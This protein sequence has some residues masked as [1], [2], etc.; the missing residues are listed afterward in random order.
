[1]NEFFTILAIAGM[2]HFTGS[3]PSQLNNMAYDR[4]E[5]QKLSEAADKKYIPQELHIWGARIGILVSAAY[6]QK[7][8]L[9]VSF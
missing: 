2:Y 7:V 9:H 1:M 6:E 3:V 4:F 8:V 5:V